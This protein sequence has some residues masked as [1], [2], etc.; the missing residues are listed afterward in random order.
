LK[1]LSKYDPE[2][3]IDALSPKKS[4]EKKAESAAATTPEAKPAEGVETYNSGDFG[5]SDSAEFEPSPARTEA[6][7]LTPESAP[8]DSVPGDDRREEKFPD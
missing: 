5:E 8:A 1:Q 4:E 7:E 3:Y 6:E 2:K